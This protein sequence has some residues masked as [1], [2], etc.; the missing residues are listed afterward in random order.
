VR[1]A[2]DLGEPDAF[3]VVGHDR[4]ARRVTIDTPDTRVVGVAEVRQPGGAFP[5]RELERRH[6]QQ[7][8]ADAKDLQQIS[9]RSVYGDDAVAETIGKER[10]FELFSRRRRGHMSILDPWI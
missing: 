9:G 10:R 1:D 3:D 8:R 2:K 6:R 4:E 5:Q 7:L